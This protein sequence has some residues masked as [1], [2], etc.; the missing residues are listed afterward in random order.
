MI[1]NNIYTNEIINPDDDFDELIKFKYANTLF[2][3]SP[4]Y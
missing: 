4:L 2:I 1:S 3:I